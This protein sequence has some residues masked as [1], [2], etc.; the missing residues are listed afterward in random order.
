M[1]P[2]TVRQGDVGVERPNLMKNFAVVLKILQALC[3]S[4]L[5]VSEARH[6]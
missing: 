2:T 5:W 6:K 1:A 3:P 4:M